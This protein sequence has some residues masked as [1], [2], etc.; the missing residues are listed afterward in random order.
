M[1]ERLF[2]QRVLKY[3]KEKRQKMNIDNL[4]RTNAYADYYEVYPEI[5]WSFLASMVSRNAGWNMCDLEGKWLPCFLNKQTRDLLFLTYERAN[6]LIFHDVYPQLLIYAISKAKGK[7]YFYLLPHFGVS[8][9]IIKEWQLFWI[10]GDQK[11][12]RTSLIINEQNI[13]QRPVIEHPFYKKKVFRSFVFT[14][15]DFLHFSC[16]LFPTIDGEIFGC[17]VHD[18]WKLTKRIELGKKL[19][20]ILFNP[21]HFE[22]FLCFSRQTPHTGSRHDYEQYLNPKKE[23]DTPILRTTFPIV[24]HHQSKNNDWMEDQRRILK[25]QKDIPYPPK[26]NVTKWY[27]KKQVELHFLIKCQSYFRHPLNQ[28]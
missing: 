21:T 9:F 7:P 17:S 15:Q 10:K 22:S 12:L 26:T 23:K 4:S 28:K 18:F 19:A 13:I 20:Q 16:V 6:W 24:S 27:Q 3:I 25:W 14:F 1:D 8:S 2:E 11:R 5:Q